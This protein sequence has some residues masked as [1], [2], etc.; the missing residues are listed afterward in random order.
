MLAKRAAG[1]LGSEDAALLQQRHHC[2]A[3][4][5][6]SSRAQRRT[7]DEPVATRRLEQ[8][9]QAVGDHLRRAYQ[10]RVHPRIAIAPPGLAQ[11]Q[12]SGPTALQDDVEHAP[13]TLL[14]VEFVERL[15]EV[16]RSAE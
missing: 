2:L 1:V 11:S 15:V 13:R 5:F 12:R 6:I 14:E 8:V 7:E 4:L 3:E 16:L 9:L 10:Q